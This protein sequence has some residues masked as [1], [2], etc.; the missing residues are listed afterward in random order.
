MISHCQNFFRTSSLIKQCYMR[1]GGWVTWLRLGKNLKKW[2]KQSQKSM[3]KDLRTKTIILCGYSCVVTTNQAK[4]CEYKLEIKK[5]MIKHSHSNSYQQF[6]SFSC[7]DRVW[8]SEFSCMALKATSIIV[9]EEI[10]SNQIPF[11]VFTN[12][13]ASCVEHLSLQQ[14]YNISWHFMFQT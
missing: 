13:F 1:G 10:H 3:R 12:L 2:Q 5:I 14:Q 11:N 4:S 6:S 9:L 8:H 7:F